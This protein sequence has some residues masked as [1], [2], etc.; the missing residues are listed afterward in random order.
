MFSNFPTSIF[1][2]NHYEKQILFNKNKKGDI[3]MKKRIGE[4]ERGFIEIESFLQTI[5]KS[6]NFKSV[7]PNNKVWFF[8]LIRKPTT[9]FM[10]IK[11]RAMSRR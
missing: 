2:F 5:F 8:L 9:D 1:I 4:N 6:W 3:S 7:F 11:F 10:E